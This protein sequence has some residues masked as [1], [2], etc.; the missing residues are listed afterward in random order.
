MPTK[1]E[2]IMGNGSARPRFYEIIRDGIASLGESTIAERSELYRRARQTVQGF[3]GSHASAAGQDARRHLA[4]LEEVIAFVEIEQLTIRARTGALPLPSP[5]VPV[6]NMDAGITPTPGGE[7]PNQRG[8][9]ARPQKRT[10]LFLRNVGA[11]S[12]ASIAKILIQLVLLPIM[13]HLLGPKQFGVYAL[14]VPMVVFLALI[15]DGGIGLSLA[16]DRTNAPEIWSTAFWILTGSGLAM[17]LIVAASGFVLAK[18][19]SEPQL[20]P[21]MLILATSFPFLSL[22]VLPVARLNRRGDLVACAAADFVSTVAGAVCA[23]ALGL[24][25]FGAKSLAFQYLA[26]YIVRAIILNVY[27]F[28]RPKAIFRPSAMLAHLSSGGV[29]I[30][31]RIADLACRSCE[32]LLFGNAFGPATLGSYNFATQV[33]RFLF[34]AFGNPSWAALFAHSLSE[35]QEQLLQIY[36]KVCRFVAFVTFPI[37]A[38]L[39]AASPE[40]MLRILGPT[41]QPA[42]VFLQIL[43]PGYAVGAVASM[44]TALLLAFNANV[45]FFLATFLL[46]FSRVI[47]AASGYYL[48]SWQSVLLVTVSHVVY[49]IIVWVSLR[50]IL[51]VNSSE[52]LREVGSSIFASI[53]AGLACRTVVEFSGNSLLALIFAVIMA[54]GIYLAVIL[55][56]ECKRFIRDLAFLTSNI[57]RM[58]KNVG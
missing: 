31:G 41:W 55:M 40:V 8:I 5:L 32:S 34:E 18:I 13:A 25:N 39:A 30:G 6:A 46:G 57:R 53:L 23:I 43:A 10:A 38:V 36:Y 22:S 28:E 12:A 44:G 14:A 52:L 9:E 51:S 15:A 49:A 37:A 56:I 35:Q 7:V 48:P 29:L 24:L 3:H 47:A 42:G 11:G 16:R 27:A 58:I 4:E 26:V 54:A 45:S 20:V 33:P 1:I 50:K 2:T 21:I 17:S 19:S